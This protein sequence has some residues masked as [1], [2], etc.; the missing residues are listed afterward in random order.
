VVEPVR[1][2][3][4]GELVV[5]TTETVRV[6]RGRRAAVLGALL[7]HRPR[8]VSVGELV[9]LVWGAHA[10]ATAVTMVH[11]AIAWLRTSLEPDRGATPG[12]L[13]GAVA[14]GYLIEQ[15]VDLDA[16]AFER[17][18]AEGRVLVE[19]APDRA[20]PVL[21]AALDLWRGPAYAGVEQPF[22]RDEAA[23]LEELRLQC[24]ELY[25][26]AVLAL[27]RADEAAAGLER[28]VA[29]QPMRERAAAVL[30]TALHAVDRRVDA[31]AVYRRV[32]RSVVDELG[33]EPGAALRA[34]AARVL[35]DG[36]G[37][38]GGGGGGRGA[39]RLPTP[40]SSFVG[41]D[42]DLAHV[43]ALLGEHRLTTLTGPGG[44]GKTRLAVEVGRRVAADAVFVDLTRAQVADLFDQTV[45]E[46]FG[47]RFDAGSV[48]AAVGAAIADEP[49]VIVLDNCEHLLDHCAA[50]VQ[51]L[52]AAHARVR[53]LAT[54]RRRLDVPGERVVPVPAL[55]LSAPTAP[56]P[57]IGASP[58][59]RLF[60]E[61]ATAARPGFAV[62]ATN[63]ALIAE[64]CRRLDALPLAVELAAA[65]TST[66][67]LR[68]LANRLDDRLLDATGRTATARH[69][70]LTATLTWSL[71]LL[72]AAERA[73]FGGLGV[74]P[75]AFDLEAVE[76]I[77]AVVDP[78]LSLSRLVE[79]SLVQA[80][81]TVERFRL[82]ETTRAFA[83]ARTAE[84]VT[85]RHRHAR[86]YLAVAHRAMPHLHHAG[87]GRWLA[88]LHRER[89]NLRAALTW[90]A[91]A[92]GNRE[93]LVG[94]CESLWHYWDVR[95][96]RGEG[97]RWLTAALEVVDAQQPQRI[98]LLSAAGLLQLG[99]AEFAATEVL[100]REQHRLA[101][102]AGDRR[103]EGDALS[104]TATVAWARG[105]YDRAQQLYEDG[106]AASLAG[107][108]LWR[109]AMAEAQL[110]RL[111]RDRHEPDAARALADRAAV[112]ADEVGE[113][114]ARGLARDVAA[115]IE[116]R[117]GDPGEAG[118]L[119]EV[120]F[121]R[122]RNVGY[123]EGE[124]SILLLFGRI[125]LAGGDPA[126][127]G[128]CLAHALR[129]Y[130]HIGHHAGVAAA[131]D[132]LAALAEEP[133][134]GRL[135]AEAATVRTEIGVPAAL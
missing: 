21:A 86:H 38:G 7:Y 94:L 135:R 34:A 12:R 95:G 68:V 4:L 107:A 47:I 103:W 57:Q 130:R 25:A 109:A 3:V 79:C 99:R 60:A 2:G 1:F 61:R 93:V 112:H 24:V 10:P 117:W 53:V 119:A 76:A 64:I 92:D 39:A 108:D 89:D 90:A 45:A 56:W 96:S 84:L 15:A 104:L 33:V 97:V 54:S 113:E 118:R 125:A 58:A 72:P 14:G 28:L 83:R 69:R 59:V 122:Y 100:A 81:R 132:A 49:V 17:L 115:S 106:I 48:A 114:L 42:D 62:T 124:A 19:A 120:A 80:D 23:R 55:A 98:S 32:R 11:G 8:P 37:D 66:M 110:A 22:A 16:T 67:S 50:F 41:R 40:I 70:S 43:G 27:G 18:L 46:A 6:G 65:R 123:R 51:E 133:T 26:A 87:S 63:A 101:V 73:L 105:R 127:A 77:T 29:D 74:F 85:L 44:T 35:G 31:A 111:H 121:E 116:H 13:I 126:R 129:T 5:E 131:L 36:D 82:L 71:S 78:A 30:M 88:G 52:L 128:R 75:A 102:A 134:S 20:E 91:S 9:D